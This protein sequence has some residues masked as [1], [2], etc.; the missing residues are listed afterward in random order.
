V[1]WDGALEA[2]DSRSVDSLDEREFP[3][4]HRFKAWSAFGLGP[5]TS[6]CSQV[7]LDVA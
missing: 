5:G 1:F 6:L 4:R 3:I 7:G 2:I